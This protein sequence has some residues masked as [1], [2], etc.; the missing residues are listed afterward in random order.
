MK[1]NRIA[2]MIV[3]YVRVYL[4]DQVWDPDLTGE[5]RFRWR[6]DWMRDQGSS[7]VWRDIWSIA[8]MEFVQSVDVGKFL[9]RC[10]LTEV[11]PDSHQW[12]QQCCLSLENELE[13]GDWVDLCQ[14]CWMEEGQVH[15]WLCLD[16][17]PEC[18]GEL[19]E[20]DH[21]VWVRVA[22]LS[23]AQ[24][25]GIGLSHLLYLSLTTYTQICT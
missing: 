20:S 21:L 9:Q 23:Q 22:L 4:Q 6:W 24:Q 10:S 15:L 19:W 13:K 25:G 16:Q 12:P 14:W 1:I 7:T 8:E 5:W 17:I 11:S 2:V 3:E 18:Q